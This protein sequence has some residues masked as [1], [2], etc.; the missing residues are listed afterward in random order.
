MPT[1]SMRICR[2]IGCGQYVDGEYC[3]AHIDKNSSKFS[4]RDQNRKLYD[5]AW[6]MYNKTSWRKFRALMLS[7][8][9]VCQRLHNGERCHNWA[10]LVHHIVSPK[11]NEGLF[12][13]ASNVICLCTHGCHPTTEGNPTDWKVNVDYVPTNLP[14]WSC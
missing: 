3:P 1:R 11:Q 4:L 9:S 7:L 10:S 6:A 8:N 13:T 2:Q 14:K 5:P 12:L